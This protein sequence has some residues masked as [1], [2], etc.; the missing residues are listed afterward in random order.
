MI[1]FTRA[2]LWL[3]CLFALGVALRTYWVSPPQVPVHYGLNGTPD[4]WGSSMSLLVMHACIIGLGTLLFLALPEFVRRA[5]SSM[6]NLPNK[7]YWLSPERRGIAAHKLATWSDTLGIGVNV[8]M[9][10]LQLVLAREVEEANVT[11]GI[12][13]GLVLGGFMLFTLCSVVW[14]VASYRIPTRS[15]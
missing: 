9:I 2:C 11:G 7:E 5:P 12:V 14:L 6:L 10:T 4:R 3:S 8:L 15:E 13:P 1:R